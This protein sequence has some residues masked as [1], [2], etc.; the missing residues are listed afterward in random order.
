MN[1]YLDGVEW[2]QNILLLENKP[3]RFEQEIQK[4]K[5]ATCLLAPLLTHSFQVHFF[6]FK[7]YLFCKYCHYVGRSWPSYAGHNSLTWT[8]T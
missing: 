1:D 4:E 2:I 8:W 3:L 6:I 5:I 7:V